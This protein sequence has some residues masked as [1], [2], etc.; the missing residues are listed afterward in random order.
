[1][2]YGSP[3]IP[4]SK[5]YH[6]RAVACRSMA[7]LCHRRRDYLLRVAVDYDRMAAQATR[8]ELQDAG[9]KLGKPQGEHVRS[10]DDV[11]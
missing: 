7:E 5:V 4:H 9:H 1:M 11:A 3:D 2:Q 8:F 6:D 10:R